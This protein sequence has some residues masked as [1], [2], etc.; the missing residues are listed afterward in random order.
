MP[1]ATKKT[2]GPPAGH[3]PLV[4]VMPWGQAVQW[5]LPVLMAQTQIRFA[6]QLHAAL[7][8]EG[9]KLGHS[10]VHELVAHAPARLT[11]EVQFAL[12]RILNCTP[13]DLWHDL[14][15]VAMEHTPEPAAR[16]RMRKARVV[17]AGELL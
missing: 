4:R 8:A 5:Q 7:L 1:T 13:A 3:G 15:Q 2:G 14:G 6:R 17:R 9:V 16:E 12:C 11:V 10:R